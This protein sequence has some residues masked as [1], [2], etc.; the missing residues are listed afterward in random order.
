MS[1]ILLLR[2]GKSDWSVDLDDFQRPL[3]DRGKRAA[4][5]MGLWLQTHDL[6]PDQIWVSP[7]KRAMETAEKTLKVMGL[8]V[9]GINAVPQLYEA[10]AGTLLDVVTE[11][12]KNSGITL[13]VGHNPSMEMALSAMV[14]AELPNDNKIMPTAALAHIT[15][16]D[17]K[18]TLVNLI[19]P[20]SLPNEFPVP[21]ATGIAYFSRPAYYYQQS[22]VIPYRWQNGLLQVLLITK[23]HKQQWG[24]PKGIIEPGYSSTASAAK[25]AMEEA[26]VLGDV[27]DESLGQYQHEKW[28]GVCHITLYPMRV[29][30]ADIDDEKW[31]SHKREREWVSLTEA[32]QRLENTEIKNMLSILASRVQELG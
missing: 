9:Q 25:E 26:G 2:H 19:K 21:T 18:A 8:P 4:Q 22:G 15:F 23:S 6:V 24:V 13:I 12:R 5:R 3:T 31:E 10:T 7:A 17:E 28:G 11:A 14:G 29:T 27:D 30:T 1:D 20:K 16:S 32:E